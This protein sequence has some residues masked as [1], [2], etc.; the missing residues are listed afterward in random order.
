M[1]ELTE[2]LFAWEPRVR[3]ADYYERALYNHILASQEPERGMFTYFMSLKPGH[4]R[5]YSTPYDS[6]WCCVGT[7]MENHTKYGKAI[8]FHNE[9][10]LFLNLFIPCVLH[11]KEKGLVLEQRTEFPRDDRVTLTVRATAE[12][13]LAL[14]VRSPGWAAGNLE[15]S[16]NGNPLPADG[17]PG[18]YATIERSWRKGDRLVVRIPMAVRA[19]RLRGASRTILRSGRP[20]RGSGPRCARRDVPVRRGSV[21]KP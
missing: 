20:R 15:F 17:T 7:G 12:T 4:F 5:T 2:H 19:E 8:W 16:L 18:R 6:F 9:D 13:P 1:L 11:W 21:G 3:Y 14:R 10:E